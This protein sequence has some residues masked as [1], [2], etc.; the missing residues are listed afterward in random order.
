MLKIEWK[1]LLGTKHIFYHFYSSSVER[2]LNSAWRSGL[3]ERIV[4]AHGKQQR[5]DGKRL[6]A[7][8]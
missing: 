8:R 5:V 4:V 1:R 6:L 3:V 2:L 7:V